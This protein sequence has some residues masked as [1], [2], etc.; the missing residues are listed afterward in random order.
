MHSP[1]K[2]FNIILPGNQVVVFNSKNANWITANQHKIIT[3]KKI[4]TIKIPKRQN[5]TR[6]IIKLRKIY[7]TIYNEK[8]KTNMKFSS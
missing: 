5:S 1:K 6:E 8:R 3:F 4:G 7:S 2:K